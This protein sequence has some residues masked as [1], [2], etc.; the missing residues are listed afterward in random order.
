M[1]KPGDVI[2]DRL[3]PPGVVIFQLAARYA[4]FGGIRVAGG[5]RVLMDAPGKMGYVQIV[6]PMGQVTIAA[7]FLVENLTR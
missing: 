5:V 7:L 4:T 1:G 6:S 3:I 2:D